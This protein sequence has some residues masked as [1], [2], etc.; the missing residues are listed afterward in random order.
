MIS[1]NLLELMSTHFE[2]LNFLYDEASLLDDRRYD[3]WLQICTDDVTYWVPGPADEEDPEEQISL[4]Y[5]NRH[6][7]EQRIARLKSAWSLAQNPPPTMQ[8]L[9]SNMQLVCDATSEH[10][11]PEFDVR[12]SFVLLET[13]GDDLV[14]WGGRVQHKIRREIDGLRIARKKVELLN[15]KLPL[16]GIKS[17]L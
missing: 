12:S 16:P 17:I 14:W 3:A 1:N 4:I 7:L 2:V 13:R 6:R 5:D 8:R 9:V 15:R 11:T 10:G